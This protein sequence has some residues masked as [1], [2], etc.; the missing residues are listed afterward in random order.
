MPQPWPAVSPD[1]TNDIE[2]VVGFGA[3]RKMP[4]LGFAPIP[5]IGDVF[6]PYPVENILPGRQTFEQHFRCE[7]VLR[8]RVR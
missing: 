5:G 3:V 4:D 6:Q 1:Q 2:P 8:Q 7:V